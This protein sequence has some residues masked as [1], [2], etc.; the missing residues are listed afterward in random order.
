MSFFHSGQGS[1][2]SIMSLSFL[3]MQYI[4]LQLVLNHF[5]DKITKATIQLEGPDNGI[6]SVGASKHSDDQVVLDSGWD[7]FVAS[8]RIQEK[9][10]LIFR[11]TENSRLEVVILDPSGHA[12]TSD[13]VRE[14]SSSTKEMSDDSL[15]I[16]DPPP[17]TLIDLSS[18]DDDD[19]MV[20]KVA[21]TSVLPRQLRGRPAKAQTTASTSASP[22][23]LRG[24]PAKAQKPAST[25]ALARQLRG[26]PAKAQKMVSTSSPSTK[27]GLSTPVFYLCNFFVPPYFESNLFHNISMNSGH[28][29]RTLREYACFSGP[30]ARK[31]HDRASVKLGVHSEPLSNNLVGP[32]QRPYVLALGKALPHRVKRKI[33]KKVQAIRS[34]VPIF[35]KVMTMTCVDA[36][37][38]KCRMVSYL[39]VS[40]K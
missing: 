32:S 1:I 29:M 38:N 40:C 26:R 12:K 4:P 20:G 23:Q 18:S 3:F 39:I 21:S 5:K 15:Q 36:V 6:Y 25:P 34:K 35:V 14:N 28:S 24:R 27:S 9:D 11:S 7:T 33:E 22:R 13:F 10:L 2:F 37:R 17:A 8:Q 31:P 16:V 30:G 19:D